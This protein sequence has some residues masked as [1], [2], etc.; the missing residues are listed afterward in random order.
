M[1]VL[2]TGSNGLLGQKLV[3][4][5]LE[6]N[7]NFTATSKGENRNSKCPNDCYRE[8]DIT[9]ESQIQGVI[10]DENPDYVI[11][12]A[13]MTNVDACELNP[14]QCELLNVTSVS[15]LVEACNATKTHFMLL[16]TDFVFDGTKGN[17]KEEDEIGPLH[18]Y[19]QSKA[20]AEAITMKNSN[21]WSIART[22]IVYGDGEELSKSNIIAWAKSAL[23]KGGPLNIVDDQFRAPTW[24][25]DLAAG[26]MAIVEK[27]QQG[28]FHLSGPETMSIFDL[29]VRI[30]K[31]FGYDHSNVSRVSSET[32]NQA[33]KR[34]PKTGFDLSKSRSVL[35][36]NPHT[37][38]ETLSIL[39]STESVG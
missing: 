22:I 37:L 33:A 9:S 29:V 17:Y 1:K 35:G 28:I 13:A 16:S 27:S 3:D 25:E 12:T 5:C 34:P 19:A 38:E 20:D 4:Y 2:I 36:Y 8:M 14:D 15:Y 39:Y 21:D 24:A 26:C 18:V 32:L 10:S 7:V 11:H 23:E 30:A 6:K 31:H